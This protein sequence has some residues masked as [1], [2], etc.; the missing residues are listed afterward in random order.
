MG[1]LEKQSIITKEEKIQYIKNVAKQN[2]LKINLEDW[3][4]ESI[5][6][7]SMIELD[8]TLIKNPNMDY[9]N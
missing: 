5:A 2:G 7:N 8:K 9:T 3:I 4:I 1:N 6:E